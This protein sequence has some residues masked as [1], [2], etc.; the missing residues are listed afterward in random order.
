MIFC[1][2]SPGKGIKRGNGK[3][4]EEER[5][6]GKAEKGKQRSEEK[7]LIVGLTWVGGEAY[8]MNE[9]KSNEQNLKENSLN[10]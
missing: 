3:G 9:Q 5:R 7:G 4:T 1:Y 2:G 8:I 6:K 10:H